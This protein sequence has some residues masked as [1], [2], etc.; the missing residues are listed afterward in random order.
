MADAD[1]K[2]ETDV[3]EDPVEAR[4]RATGGED[5]PGAADQHGVT[6]TTPNDEYVGRVSG[7][8]PGAEGESGAERRAQQSGGDA[9][10]PR[11]GATPPGEGGHI[12]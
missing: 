1:R 6:S 10:G 11:A 3:D 12:G 5:E 7:A 2:A 9:E 4:T 8:D